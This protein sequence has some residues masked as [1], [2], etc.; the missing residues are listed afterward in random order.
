[1]IKKYRK[2]PVV[3]EALEFT[4]DNF[5]DVIR[6]TNG[7][8][9]DFRIPKHPSGLAMCVIPTLEGNHIAREGDLI[10]KGVHGEFYPCKP[11]I[12]AKTYEDAAIDPESLRPKGEWIIMSFWK[13]RRGHHVQYV[14]KKCSICNFRVKARWK[15]NFCPHC[16]ADMRGEA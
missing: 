10:I 9:T 12:F 5:E 3:I 6:F 7:K 1:M 11:D 14:V 15:N 8:V 2:K 4:R 16:G 13:K